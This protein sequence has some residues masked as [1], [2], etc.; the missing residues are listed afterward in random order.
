MSSVFCFFWFSVILSSQKDW[1]V[2]SSQEDITL[3]TKDFKG[4]TVKQFKLKTSVKD[5]INIV[6]SV[7]KDVENMHLWY[8]RVTSVNLLHKVSDNEGIYLLEYGLPFPFENRVAT[9]SGKINYDTLNKKIEVLTNYS[10]FK[11][12]K[13][14]SGLLPI[15]EIQSSWQVS[16]KS[17][18]VIEIIHSGHMNPGGNIPLWLVNDGVNIRAC[19][20]Y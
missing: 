5:D 17:E 12:P 16:K 1:Q 6:Y 9:I 14:K 7:L 10:P 15:T 11:I 4:S 8:D 19:K 13:Q 20:N 18:G 2:V 3:W